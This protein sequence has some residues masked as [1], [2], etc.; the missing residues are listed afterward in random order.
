MSRIRDGTAG[1]VANQKA[2]VGDIIGVYS[3]MR[4]KGEVDANTK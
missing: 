1:G 2:E 3:I 4:K